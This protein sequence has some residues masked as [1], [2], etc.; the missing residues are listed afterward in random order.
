M[1]IVTMT[2]QCPNASS[3]RA[4]QGDGAPDS[5]TPEMI[6]AGVAILWELETEVSKEALAKAVYQAMES[7]RSLD[8]D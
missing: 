6:K 8:R 1:H 5:I 2:K 3:G 4:P 7:Q